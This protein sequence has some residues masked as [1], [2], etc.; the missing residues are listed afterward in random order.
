[1]TRVLGS[2]QVLV[3]EFRRLDKKRIL[4]TKFLASLACALV[5]AAS[6]NAQT[7]APAM[8]N[9]FDII[10]PSILLPNMPVREAALKANDDCC[11]CAAADEPV[12]KVDSLRFEFD[13]PSLGYQEM[14]NARLLLHAWRSR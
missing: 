12:V 9:K 2:L 3:H 6:L 8:R 5:C 11:F 13:S 1:M 4:V 7:S 14:A 10:T